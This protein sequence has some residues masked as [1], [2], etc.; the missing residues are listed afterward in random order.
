MPCCHSFQYQKQT[1]ITWFEVQWQRCGIRSVLTEKCSLQNDGEGHYGK[2]KYALWA[3]N[4]PAGKLQPLNSATEMMCVNM[5]PS[6]RRKLIFIFSALI[7]H[8]MYL[9]LCTEEWDA[10]IIHRHIGQNGSYNS[11][12]KHCFTHDEMEYFSSNG[13]FVAATYSFSDHCG[14]LCAQS[15]QAYWSAS[16]LFS[17]LIHLLSMLWSHQS[18]HSWSHKNDGMQKIPSIT[19]LSFSGKEATFTIRYLF[20]Y[21]VLK[22]R[23]LIHIAV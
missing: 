2:C 11:L 8:K 18:T 14:R 23:Y 19:R 1:Q 4:F 16:L 5:V 12:Y 13:D 20:F 15:P 17:S 21:D 9:V 7:W 6:A 22:N 10:L 3:M